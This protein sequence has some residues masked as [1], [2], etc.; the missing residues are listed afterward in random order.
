MHL[1]V[2]VLMDAAMDSVRML[3]FL[4]AAF[5][6]LEAMEKHAGNFSQRVLTG[7]RG[8][9]PVLGAVLGCVPQ[10]GF[11]VLAANLFSGGMISAGTLLAVF[12]STSDEAILMILGQP[13]SAGVVGRLLLTKVLIAVAAGYL[14]DL[15]F[16][17]LFA[18]KKEIH[19]LCEKDS[20]GCGHSHGVLLPA[21]NHTIRL[22][23]YILAFSACLNLILE[24][25]GI[26]KVE[27][28]FWSGSMFQP[29][30]TALIGF[31][32]NCAASVLLTELYMKGV[33]SFA[34]A[35]A[36]LCTSAGVGLVVLWR[37]NR[38]QKEN[39][40]LMG[41][42]YAVAVVSGIMLYWIK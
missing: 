24:V 10:C 18:G 39:L 34:A 40:K 19:D 42:L 33:I 30:L 35:V 25:A 16:P 22:F 7:I 4:F 38:D 29:V 41:V 21:W 20:C 17:K 12:L 1:V 37:V 14:V 13:E 28:L 27:S 26:G 15:C 6:L 8:A 9:G 23:V 5:C 3:P 2:D 11:S 36:G 32:P 31:I